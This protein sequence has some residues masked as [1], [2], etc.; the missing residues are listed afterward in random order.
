MQKILPVSGWALD[1]IVALD[2]RFAGVC[3][4]FLRASG[5]RRQVIAALLST[6]PASFDDD[7]ARTV[8]ELITT[9]DHLSILRAGFSEPPSG[10][11]GAL[12]KA[13]AQPHSRVFYRKLRDLLAAQGKRAQVIKQLR[14]VDLDRL[15]ITELLPPDICTPTLVSRLTSVRMA[16]DVSALFTLLVENGVRREGLI[17]A[18]ARVGCAE[19][20]PDLWE[21][22][23]MKCRFPAHPVPAGPAYLPVTSGSGLR[24]LALSYRNCMRSYLSRVLDEQAAFAEAHYRAE[25]A[26]VHLSRSS[27]T[28][29]LGGMYGLAN[30]PVSGTLRSQVVSY[31]A[32]HGVNEPQHHHESA[33]AWRVLRR[34]TR[35]RFLFDIPVG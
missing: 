27:G 5:E 33:G 1:M 20:F 31:L 26:V 25:S 18:L 10:M 21:R 8:G 23:A 16:S 6:H 19:D 14:Q 11:R 22:W 35:S 15:R 3:G 32:S 34:L 24:R 2:S 13:G 28:W 30:G 17:D 29:V 9:A 12:A 7:H 4:A